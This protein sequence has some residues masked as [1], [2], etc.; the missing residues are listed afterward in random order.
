VKPSIAAIQRCL[1]DK[2]KILGA[3]KT[4]LVKKKQ[5]GAKFPKLQEAAEEAHHAGD[6]QRLL[7]QGGGRGRSRA[8]WLHDPPDGLGPHRLPPRQ[9][10]LHRAA[11]GPVFIN[12]F[13]AHYKQLQLTWYLKML[14]ANSELKD[15]SQLR[16]SVSQASIWHLFLCPL[17]GT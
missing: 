16:C 15:V 2:E 5:T 7:A 12:S 8:A 3:S 13:K 14:D 9:H 1:K 11:A 4:Q 17:F 6:G 10:H